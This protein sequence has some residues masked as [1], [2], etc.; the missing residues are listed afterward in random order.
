M[1][2]ADALVR[3]AVFVPFDEVFEEVF[4]LPAVVFLV[5][6][7]V[8]F[9]AANNITP[10]KIYAIGTPVKRFTPVL[11][12]MIEITTNATPTTAV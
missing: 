8:F 5:L 2:T 12:S 7:A 11:I 9:L 1:G 3:L 10:I 6:S 4:F